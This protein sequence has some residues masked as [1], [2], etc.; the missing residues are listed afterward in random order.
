MGISTTANSKMKYFAV[1]ALLAIGLAQATPT[2]DVWELFKAVH[3]KTYETEAEDVLRKEIFLNNVQKIEEHNQKFE[4]GEVSFKLGV[5]QFA[6]LIESEYR[7][8]QLGFKKPEGFKSGA[9][10]M[11]VA[12]AGVELPTTVDWRKK[13]VV[14]AVKNQAQCGSCWAFS[15][16]GSVEG[17]HALKTGDLVS[18][19]E[20]QLV[21]CSKDNNGCGGGLMDLAFKYIIAVG[22]LE[23]ESEYPYTSGGGDDT[24]KCKF[25]KSKVKATISSYVDVKRE[26]EDALKQAV[27]TVGPISVAIDAS[28]MSFQLYNGG[29]YH[30]WLCSQTELDHG[31]LVVGYGTE[32]GKDYWLVKNSWQASWGEEGYIKMS[33]N[34]NNNCGIA[35]QASYP[36]V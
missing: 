13:G 8:S 1:F 24:G 6:D 26:D 35:T 22:G 3:Q 4:A 11:F 25:S 12:D 21:E 27:A 2:S 31:V 34:R 7:A 18:L 5:N 29:V 10:G 20:E 17:A 15:T 32:D 28:H 9:S 14:T 30:E 33:R 19:S 23:S 16:T 36:V